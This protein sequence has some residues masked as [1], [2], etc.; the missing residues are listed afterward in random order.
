ML[1]LSTNNEAVEYIKEQIKYELEENCNNGYPTILVGHMTTKGSDISNLL[2]SYDIS[3]EI[4]LPINTFE[5]INMSFFGHIHTF[6]TLS[7]KPYIVNLGSIERNTFGDMGIDKKIATVDMI[8]NDISCEFQNLPVRNIY[9]IQVD[10]TQI[11]AVE[12]MKFIILAL[13]RYNKE[14]NLED[15]IVRMKIF[16][17]SANFNEVDLQKIRKYLR[18]KNIFYCTGINI[19]PITMRQPRRA[20]IT[21]KSSDL[22]EFKEYLDLVVDDKDFRTQLIEKGENIIIAGGAE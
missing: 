1:K 21:E 22:D 14:N 2:L 9:E 6:S 10:C 7:K 3:S 11:P 15:G 8:N 19:I 20:S 12:T 18:E 16:V 17:S 4:I 5:N 13:R